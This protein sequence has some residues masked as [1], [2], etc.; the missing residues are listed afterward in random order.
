MNSLARFL[1]IF[2]ATV[3]SV[4]VANPIVVPSSLVSELTFSSTGW[5]LELWPAFYNPLNG[6][7]IHTRTDS[8]Q[9]IPGL[10]ANDSR[11]VLTADSLSTPLAID[12]TGDSIVVGM[13]GLPNDPFVFGSTSN[14]CIGAPREGH[15]I[16]FSFSS[17]SYYFDSS[18][19]LGLWNDTLGANARLIVQVSDTNGLP[20]SGA[21]VDWQTF[22][23]YVDSSGRIDARS[24]A[25]LA[26][27]QASATNYNNS[28]QTIQLYPGQT[29]SV[30][31]VMT[32]RISSVNSLDEHPASFLLGQNYPNPFNAQTTFDV[33]MPASGHLTVEVFDIG[34]QCVD[35]LLSQW[36]NEGTYRLGW[37]GENRS[38]GIYLIRAR[39]LGT[40]AVRKVLL[41]R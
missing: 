7:W 13:Y 34:G 4:T 26:T 29:D 8:A 5:K 27:V 23:D 30:S 21:F 37:K 1:P 24:L 20:I 18:P 11:L 32:S 2:L 19:T 31:L 38:S 14:S 10:K 6:L 25:V 12:P 16:S 17:M 33:A 9:V 36:V 39:T 35:V 40:Q 41:L 22:G 15:S 28:Y 3:L